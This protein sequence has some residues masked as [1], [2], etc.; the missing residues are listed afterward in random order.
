[1]GDSYYNEATNVLDLAAFEA[2]MR[3]WTNTDLT[4]AD[5]IGHLTGA[6]GG[7]DNG[8]YL[9]NGT[10]VREESLSVQDLLTGNA[11]LDWFF[12]RLDGSTV[13]LITDADPL[14]ELVNSI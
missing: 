3:E 9:L 14:L 10:T 2:V 12:A 11:D 4:Y 8:E 5:R 1:M 6:L 13:D 7:G